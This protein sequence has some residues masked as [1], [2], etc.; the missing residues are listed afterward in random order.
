MEE[1]REER[2]YDLLFLCLLFRGMN[3]IDDAQTVQDHTVLWN[4]MRKFR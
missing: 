1:F 4:L 3:K 2:Y